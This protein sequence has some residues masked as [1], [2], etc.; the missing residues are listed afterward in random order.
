MFFSRKPAVSWIVVFLGNPC[1]KY[2]N[3]RH[4]I[5]FMTAE[6]IEKKYNLSI[7]RL[8]FKALTA[9]GEI[10]GEKVFFMKPQTYMNLSG[11]AVK[12]A[13]DFY[14]VPPDHILVISDDIT[15][16][17]GR[18]RLRRSGSAGGHNGLKNIIEKIGD[19]FPRLKVG[20]GIPPH[21]DYS[22]IDWVL[23]SFHGKDADEISAAVKRAADAVESVIV[24]GIDKTMN[25]FNS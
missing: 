22:I 23:S 16:D 24:N 4:N 5:G 13:A 3:T 14:K 7:N 19:G 18:L 21:P 20:V 1:A 6:V 12:P 17:I 25:K 2:A 10:N 15:L 11:E 9:L 8:K